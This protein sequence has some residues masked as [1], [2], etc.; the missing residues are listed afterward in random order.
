MLYHG[1]MSQARL[2]ELKITEIKHFW[3]FISPEMIDNPSELIRAI[4]DLL[5]IQYPQRTLSSF[6]HSGEWDQFVILEW[7]Y[8][9]VIENDLCSLMIDDGNNVTVIY[10]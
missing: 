2:N 5:G 4:A 3:K 8:T 9:C 10:S 7:A 6:T 1:A